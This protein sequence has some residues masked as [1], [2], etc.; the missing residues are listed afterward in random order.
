MFKKD[1]SGLNSDF[2]KYKYALLLELE[3]KLE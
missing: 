2:L 1:L 3:I